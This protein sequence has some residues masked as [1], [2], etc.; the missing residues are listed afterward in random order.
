MTRQ[1]ST[2]RS[3]ATSGQIGRLASPVSPG[4][5]PSL[6]EEP[7]AACA[8]NDI[9]SRRRSSGRQQRVARHCCH[10]FHRQRCLHRERRLRSGQRSAA[11]NQTMATDCQRR[12]VDPSSHDSRNRVDTGGRTPGCQP[13]AR[14][15][16]VD[17]DL[18]RRRQPLLIE[19]EAPADC[20]RARARLPI[21]RAGVA[22]RGCH[23]RT[24]VGL[25]AIVCSGVV[26]ESGLT[27]AVCRTG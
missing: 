5:S 27:K 9:P 24:T 20:R 12:S 26:S 2:R 7:A 19:T 25:A 15:P 10:V 13:A 22:R 6:G 16:C 3:R 14:L 23:R 17:R 21:Y 4:A 11:S 8:A 1:E 18:R